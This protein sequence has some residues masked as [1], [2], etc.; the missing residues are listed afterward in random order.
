VAT[1]PIGIVKTAPN[2]PL[3]QAFEDYV[4]SPPGR[5]DLASFGFLP[6]S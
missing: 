1:Y 5:A 3:A 6:P 4:L 2:P